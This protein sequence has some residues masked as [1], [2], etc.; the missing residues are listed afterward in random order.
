[1]PIGP[2]LDDEDDADQY[3]ASQEDP[4]LPQLKQ[5]MALETLAEITEESELSDASTANE[6]PL[7]IGSALK[8]AQHSDGDAEEPL[9]PEKMHSA[10]SSEPARLQMSPVPQS[11]EAVPIIGNQV[12]DENQIAAVPSP[13]PQLEAPELSERDKPASIQSHSSEQ[14]PAP[15]DQS[16]GN[17]EPI[18]MTNSGQTAATAQLELE[19]KSP[20]TNAR[21]ANETPEGQAA[22]AQAGPGMSQLQSPEAVNV[23][24]PSEAEKAVE[25]IESSNRI[26]CAEGL[27]STPVQQSLEQIPETQDH[28]SQSVKGLLDELSTMYTPVRMLGEQQQN[29]EQETPAAH[30]FGDEEHMPSPEETEQD[31][32]PELASPV[33]ASPNQEAAGV[34]RTDIRH[35]IASIVRFPTPANSPAEGAYNAGHVSSRPASATEHPRWEVCS[36][37]ESAGNGD[38][39]S[40]VGRSIAP[41]SV[42]YP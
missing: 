4:V 14:Q 26:T 41:L 32:S 19:C 38:V 39:K 36:Q 10:H 31:D 25:A 15:D 13:H 8:V 28:A 12:Q 3:L 21:A 37:P 16:H 33:A 35:V 34:D 42:P 20:I 5:K 9:S 23:A 29:I 30:G 11:T 27:S 2:G 1:M 17:A 24:S 6:D 7:P 22:Q 40:F 18:E